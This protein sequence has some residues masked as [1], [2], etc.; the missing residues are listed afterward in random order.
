VFDAR[1]TKA[2]GR[3]SVP[4]SF[5]NRHV[6]EAY[7]NPMVGEAWRIHLYL[8]YSAMSEFLM[9]CRVGVALLCIIFQVNMSTASFS[10]SAPELFQ[11]QDY[12]RDILGK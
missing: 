1:H 8:W 3:W 5:P 11:I 7:I 4:E 9:N 2:R 10:F 12:C 6:A